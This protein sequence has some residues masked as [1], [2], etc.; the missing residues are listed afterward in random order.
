MKDLLNFEMKTET[1]K[2]YKIRHFSKEEAEAVARYFS[3]EAI[4]ES[5]ITDGK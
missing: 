1:G 3:Q 2:V 4:V 5:K